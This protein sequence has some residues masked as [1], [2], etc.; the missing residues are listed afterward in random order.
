MPD[1]I[2]A[3]GKLIKPDGSVWAAA[4]VTCT[5]VNLST[6]PTTQHP[7]ARLTTTTAVDGSYSF[8]LWRN[9]LG[10]YASH[11]LFKFPNDQVPRKA[12][13]TLDTPVEVEISQLLLASTDPGDPA[14]PSL[15]AL[16]N[17]LFA[18]GNFSASADLVPLNPPIAGL[19]LNV[20]GAI[21]ALHDGYTHIQS[22]ASA[23]WIVNHN[24][25]VY[26]EASVLTAGG[27][28]VL[29]EIL[30]VSV[31]QMRV[32]FSTPFTGS[33]RCSH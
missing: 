24:L 15:V 10:D 7:P 25:G 17:E 18:A 12:I 3:K 33:V 8:L 9:E 26:P 14:Y 4:T 19:P 2:L 11:Y 31:N 30:H 20:Q 29:T 21:A 27:Q 28:K 16:I 5:F 1:E 23:E 6:T 32:Y 22:P 13:I